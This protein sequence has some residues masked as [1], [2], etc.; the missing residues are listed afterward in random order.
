[1]SKKCLVRRSADLLNCELT[2]LSSSSRWNLVYEGGGGGLNSSLVT[3][4]GLLCLSLSN[5]CSVNLF[6]L[7]STVGA[8]CPGLEIFC[9]KWFLKHITTHYNTF[10]TFSF[11]K[12]LLPPPS[13]CNSCHHPLSSF[14]ARGTYYIKI[15]CLSYVLLSKRTNLSI[16]LESYSLLIH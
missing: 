4:S 10:Q 16:I 5:W 15:K 1:M 11:W 2:V 14:A 6:F 3:M 7:L 8:P 12:T 13:P 9:W